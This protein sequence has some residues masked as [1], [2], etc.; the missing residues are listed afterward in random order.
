MD[1]LGK[2]LRDSRE[3]KGIRLDE[4]AGRTKINLRYL[5]DLE[6][7]RFE[8]LP[9]PIFT[10]GF[11]KQYAQCVGLDP[12]D[13][14]ALYRQIRQGQGAAK[15]EN[16]SGKA[17]W[18]QKRS[19]LI[20]ATLVAILVLLWLS[21]QPETPPNGERV[22]SIRLPR[23]SPEE[24]NKERLRKELNLEPESP[25]DSAT[26]RTLFSTQAE[27]APGADLSEALPA[28]LP[29]TITIQA[30]RKTWVQVTV[31]DSPPAQLDLEAGNQLSYQAE[32][33][34]ALK[35]G[36]GNGVRVFYHGKVLE[37]LGREDEVVH[38]FFPPPES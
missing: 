22:R 11:L 7:G 35:I 38:V 3:Q 13:V 19:Y 32:R 10:I 17:W 25:A 27:V 26:I 34:I 29:V 12:Q 33:R 6:E 37:N 5:E 15:Q 24:M 14:I 2:Y 8:R 9:A 16:L 18:S 30:L 4:V 31:D 28:G 20:M 36:N 21:L 23:S 1:S